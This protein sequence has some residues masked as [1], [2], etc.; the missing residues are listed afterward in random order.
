MSS[1]Q[2]WYHYKWTK[3]DKFIWKIYILYTYWLYIINNDS[4]FFIFCVC[5]MFYIIENVADT[6]NIKKKQASNYNRANYV[7]VCVAGSVCGNQLLE[8]LMTR[9]PKSQVMFASTFSWISDFFVL[10]A[11]I[12][13]TLWPLCWI[14]EYACNEHVAHWCS[15]G[16]CGDGLDL[17]PWCHNKV[18]GCHCGPGVT[19]LK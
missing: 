19:Q 17:H 15:D 18:G 10:L 4:L 16:G 8:R 13:F 3:Y 9:S 1:L 5:K 6:C 11:F 2:N 12:L 7:A 14:Y